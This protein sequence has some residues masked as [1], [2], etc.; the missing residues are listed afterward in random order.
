MRF[1]A[2]DCN[3][4]EFSP[5]KKARKIPDLQLESGRWGGGGGCLVAERVSALDN[6]PRRSIVLKRL[7]NCPLANSRPSAY[8]PTERLWTCNTM[9]QVAPLDHWNSHPL[10]VR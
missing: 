10:I 3:K 4:S 2:P 7:A 8:T 9:Q 1:S 6:P 5:T